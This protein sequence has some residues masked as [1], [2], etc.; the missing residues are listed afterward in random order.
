MP[1]ATPE[2]DALF[3]RRAIRLAMN[4]RGRVEPNPMVGCVIVRD[5]RVIGEAYH[6]RFGGPHAEPSALA[7]CIES[8]E[9]AT[10][11]TTLEPCC[12]T[13]KKTPPCVPRLIEAKVG[14]VVVGCI[15]PD[16]RVNGRGVEQLRAAGV[17]VTAPV[18]EAECKQL[19]APFIA[20]VVHKRPYVTL[21]WAET[22][23]GKVAGPGGLPIR[24]T[25]DIAD[26]V[27]HELRTRCDAILIGA[28]TALSDNPRLTV[29]V[30]SIRAPMRVVLDSRLRLASRSNLASTAH[31]APVLV[32]YSPSRSDPDHAA[33]L[34]EQGVELFPID[35]S[36]EA[37]PLP[38]VLKELHGRGVT[39]VLVEPGP[40]LAFAFVTTPL[41]DRLWVFRS[42]RHVGDDAAR[43]AAP[44]PSPF[45]SVGDLFVGD[46]A[47]N[48]LTEYLNPSSPV[49]TA[50][51]PS[52]DFVLACESTGQA[53]AQ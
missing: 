22:A 7:A 10:V 50:P 51:E 30:P 46:N 42:P 35:H 14:R 32:F 11:Y 15:D 13:D 33:A 21:K 34:R 53:G 5:G 41:T 20:H 45:V 4:G 8:P 27:V 47:I 40:T 17:D 1:A 43:S 38:D 9:G 48:K 19:L 2:Q 18:L 24:I 31:R 49:F 23:D 29:R 39:N 25:N 12:H 52:A 37:M 3:M 16:P 6:Q 44:I 28:G 26:R 36:Q